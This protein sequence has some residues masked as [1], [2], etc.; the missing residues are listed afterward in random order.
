MIWHQFQTAE[1][2]FGVDCVPGL[3][4]SISAREM[5]KFTLTNAKAAIR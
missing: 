5:G 1:V 3:V 4:V 2:H